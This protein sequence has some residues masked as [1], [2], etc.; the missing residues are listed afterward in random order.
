VLLGPPHDP[1]NDGRGFVLCPDGAFDRSPCGTGTSA[2]VGCLFEDG[3]L[4]EGRTWRQESVLGGVYDASIRRAGEAMIP[5]VRGHAWI[6]SESVLHFT[7]D[8]PYRTGLDG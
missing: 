3:L 1:G 2:L 4:A 6:T 5:S 8:D 7:T